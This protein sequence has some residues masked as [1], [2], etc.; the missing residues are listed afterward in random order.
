MLG[1]IEDNMLDST[2]EPEEMANILDD[3]EEEIK[4]DTETVFKTVDKMFTPTQ[5]HENDNLL[6]VPSIN[7]VSKSSERSHNSSSKS[8]S[9]SKEA[10]EIITTLSGILSNENPSEK[11]KSEGQNLLSSLAE[12]FISSASTKSRSCILDDSGN[13]SIE[14]EQVPVSETAEFYQ[15]L[16]LRKKSTSESNLH[17]NR[18]FE[19]DVPLDLS[20]KSKTFASPKI[21]PPKFNSVM[22]INKSVGGNCSNSSND[23]KNLSDPTKKFKPKKT[24]SLSVRRGPM[25]AVL[26]VDNMAKKG[27]YFRL[28]LH[29]IREF[30]QCYKLIFIL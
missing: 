11:Q 4:C 20:M 1:D 29:D 24:E 25:R 9:K 16:D 26:P 3:E 28:L 27:K 8:P 6:P 30:F 23:S 21:L 18:S 5:N 15:V 10:L 19:N 12:I 7:N 22:K 2:Q 17:Q 13:S 14:S